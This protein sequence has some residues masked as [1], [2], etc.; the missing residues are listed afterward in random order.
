MKVHELA[1]LMGYKTADFIEE[2]NK[3]GIKNKNHA[4]NKL[5]D[6]DVAGI[7]KVFP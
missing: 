4:N 3:I 1:K 5:G 2:L 7:V 6:D